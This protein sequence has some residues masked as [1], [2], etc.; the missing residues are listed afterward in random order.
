MIS[1]TWLQ[2]ALLDTFLPWKKYLVVRARKP[3]QINF[4]YH[5]YK[6]FYIRTNEFTDNHHV[7]RAHYVFLDDHHV[8]RAQCVLLTLF[9]MEVGPPVFD[10]Q[11]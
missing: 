4:Y 11:A 8:R 1:E 2:R 5:S 6:F 9:A 3:V 7:H 10:E